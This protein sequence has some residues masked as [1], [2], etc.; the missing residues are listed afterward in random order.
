MKN[1]LYLCLFFIVSLH[2]QMTFDF[3]EHANIEAATDNQYVRM[4]MVGGTDMS[5]IPA[6]VELSNQMLDRLQSQFSRTII[7][8][9]MTSQQEKLFPLLRAAHF[10]E[11]P[12]I[13]QDPEEFMRDYG[14]DITKNFHWYVRNNEQ[15]VAPY[16]SAFD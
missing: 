6:F 8:G 11:D 15:V 7:C 10:V 13:V 5:N 1:L 4:G 14:L 2:A 3:V 12:S 9:C 16:Q